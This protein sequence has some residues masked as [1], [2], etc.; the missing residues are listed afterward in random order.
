MRKVTTM[1]LSDIKVILIL[2]FILSF[3]SVK[4]QQNDTLSAKVTYESITDSD[5]VVQ[6]S[7]YTNKYDRRI[8]RYRK[9]WESLIPTHFKLQYAGNMGFLSAGIGWDYGKRG[10]W[11]TDL[12]LGIIPQ[13]S[14]DHFKLT[15]TLKQSYVPW[16]IYLRENFSFEPL[17]CGI[18]FNTV[19]SDKF[20]TREP[21]RYPRGYY[22]FSTRIRTHAF[23]GQRI[24]IDI[25]ESKRKTLKSLTFFYE[26]S[27]CDLYI[28]S[29]F[30]NRKLR[31]DDFLVLSLGV[32]FQIF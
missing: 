32:K 28:V 20:W 19:F 22:G 16:S 17:E 23:I 24:K 11:E 13:Y 8:H 30:R 9:A 18:Y 27:S 25:P 6:K 29:A 1:K 7:E 2:L 14:S 31:P 26:V 21:E 4:A 5:I 10:Q 12:L 15:L 3:I